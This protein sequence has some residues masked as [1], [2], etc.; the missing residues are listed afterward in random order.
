[1]DS[2]L[3]QEACPDSCAQPLNASPGFYN[4]LDACWQETSTQMSQTP[5]E[6]GAAREADAPG[7]HALMQPNLAANGGSLSANLSLEQIAGML[8]AMPMVV[9]RRGDEV[10]GFLLTC[11]AEDGRAIPILK[12]MLEAYPGAPGAYVYGPICVATEQRG[13]GIAQAMFAALRG[14]LPG[15]E[16]ILFVRADN[17]ASLRA[18]ARMAMREVARFHFRSAEHVVFAYTG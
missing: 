2:F 11:S 9:A 3:P 15:R 16:G 4:V 14:L 1:M 6:I 5:I 8:A 17:E 13:Q 7:I 18:H 10:L 12:A